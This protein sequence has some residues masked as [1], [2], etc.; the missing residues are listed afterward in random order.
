MV[1]NMALY[2][3]VFIAR[4]DISNAQ[5]EGLIEHFSQVLKDNGGDVASF[6]YW[7]LRSM[8][9]KINK[10]RKGHYALLRSDA[11]SAAVAEMERLMR[12]HD[13][14]MRVMTIK[15]DEHEEGESAIIRA[16]AARDE[17]NRGRGPRPPRRED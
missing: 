12:L 17:R 13:D 4:Q 1:M 9:F 10:N 7:G 11:P 16:K 6:E 2:E 8:A 15:V 3:H 14:V 5:A